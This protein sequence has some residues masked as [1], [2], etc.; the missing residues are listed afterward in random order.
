MPMYN[1]SQG[2]RQKSSGLAPASGLVLR[3]HSVKDTW[4]TQTSRRH[5]LLSLLL[6]VPCTAEDKNPEVII[7]EGSTLE[8]R[9]ASSIEGV[10]LLQGLL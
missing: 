3:W 7:P 8:G 9:L 2:V 5:A 1:H 6:R 4:N 10:Q